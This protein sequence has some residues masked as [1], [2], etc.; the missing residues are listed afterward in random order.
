[1][2]TVT[3][4]IISSNGTEYIFEKE[5]VASI[6][7]KNCVNCGKCREVCPVGAISERQRTIC[8]VCPECTGKPALTLDDMYS[9]ATE[10][11]CTTACPL[12]ISPQG[13]VNLAGAGKL[14]EAYELIWERTRS[15]PCVHAYVIIR[16]SRLVN[17]EFWWMNPLRSEASN[18]I[19]ERRSIGSPFPTQSCMKRK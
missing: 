11:A 7:P 18:D 2:K 9:L 12:G 1:M 14:N 15:L 5:A 10:K 13:Y 4:K 6:N 17:A 19:S 16:A 8:R 3:A